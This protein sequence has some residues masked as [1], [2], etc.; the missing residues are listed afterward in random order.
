[1]VSLSTRTLAILTLALSYSQV[2]FAMPTGFEKRQSAPIPPYV[3]SYAPKVWIHSE[4]LYFPSDI[5]AQLVNTKPEVDFNVVNGAPDPLTLDNLAS[6]N[7]LGGSNVYLTSV[8]DVET[9]PAWLKGV[10]PDGNGK[11]NGATSSAVI[12]NDRGSGNVDAYYMYF[13]AYN[14]GPTVFGQEVGKHVGD[15]EH[16]MIRFKNGV[17]QAIWYSQHSYGQAFT[18][19]ATE[20]QGQRPVAYSAKH[21]H[22]NYATTGTH[23]YTIPGVNLPV[24]P[25]KDYC[26]QGTLWDPV[27]SA[28]F[29]SYNSASNTFMAYDG[30]SPTNWLE[31]LGR[32]GDQEY[33]DSD[34]RQKK[35]FGIDA[36]AKY[37]SGPTGPQDKSL[38]RRDVCLP[39]DRPC[40]VSPFLR[41]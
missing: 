7:G 19:A 26:D 28:Y 8:D 20:K 15:W 21:T 6:L 24:G 34:P 1:M 40:F 41:P 23:D 11:T 35:I 5:G 4:D 13:Y 30:T 9:N 22:A 14:P 31:F 32:W 39:K 2:T 25:L 18:Y 36:T 29:Y 27:A 3:L 12:V 33:P 37:T 16:N 17:P 10:K 38:N